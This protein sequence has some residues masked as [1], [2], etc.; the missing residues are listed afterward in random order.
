MLISR[1][2]TSYISVARVREKMGHTADSADYTLLAI[3]RLS[4]QEC[5]TESNTLGAET[6]SHANFGA[7]GNTTVNV[8]FELL[9]QMG[10]LPVQRL[11]RLESRTRPVDM[12]TAF[13][14]P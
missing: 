11:K 1:S 5:A 13:P 4:V 9:E 14:F 7:A 2:K 12:S 8:D 10:L 3:S 6:Q